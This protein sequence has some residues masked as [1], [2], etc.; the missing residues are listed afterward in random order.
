[1]SHRL[2]KE[3]VIRPLRDLL[4]LLP[5]LQTDKAGHVDL[6]HTPLPVLSKLIE[7]AEDCSSTLHRGISAI[8]SLLAHA[9]TE[10]EDG[11]IGSDSVEALGWLLAEL[12]DYGAACFMLAAQC[13]KA[14]AT[15]V[16]NKQGK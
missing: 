8:G 9:A 6:T 10:I 16:T 4:Q 13:R 11:T 12:G 1:M 5:Q 3:C 14:K 15:H 7:H 2:S